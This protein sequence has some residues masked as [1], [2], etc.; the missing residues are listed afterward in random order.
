MPARLPTLDALLEESADP[1]KEREI[2]TSA[3]T[4][5]EVAFVLKEK[6]QKALDLQAERNIDAL[7][8]DRYAV[9]LIDLHE[10]IATGARTLIREAVADG[11]S[12]KPGDAIHLATARA[13][14]CQDLHTYSK[15]LPRFSRLIGLT[16]AE[17]YTAQARRIGAPPNLL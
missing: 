5:A 6:E 15:D 17:P 12:L 1:E 9:K 14:D 13:L 16:I 4:I 11:L 8:S 3:F 2:V 7:W 10:G